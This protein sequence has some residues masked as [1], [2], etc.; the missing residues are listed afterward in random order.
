MQIL[1]ARFFW[2]AS[3][4]ALSLGA[5]ALAAAQ[6]LSFGQARSAVQ[7][8][9]PQLAA[10]LAAVASAQL[11]REGMEGLGGP[12]VAVTAMAY[13]YAANVDVGLDPARHALGNALGQFPAAA[14]GAIGQLPQLPSNYT[15]QR[16]D[17][18]ASASVSALWPVYMGGLSDA[19][20]EGLDGKT[21]EA[22]ADAALSQD[23]VH[24]LLV[25][26]YFTAQLAERAAILRRRALQGVRAHDDAAQRMLQAG[27]IAQVERLQASA[28]LADAQQQSQQADSAARLARSALAHTVQAPASVQPTTPLFVNQQPLAPLHDFQAAALQ[29][30]P[31]LGKVAAKRTQAEA[32]HGA[33]EALRKPQVL[34][35]GMR[36]VNTSGKPNWV[37]GMAVRWTLWDSMDRD[38]L[39]AAGQ[40]AIEQA[41]LSAAQVRSDIALLVE[42][43]WLAVEQAR[44]SYQAGQ[45]QEDLA[46]ELLRLRTAGFKEGT[47]TALEVIDAQLQVAKVQTARAS[48]ANDYVQ[49]L[50]ALLESSGQTAEFEQYMARADIVMS[51]DAP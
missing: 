36:E 27:V 20:R 35:F 22:Q 41:D 28:A 32:L 14:A 26:R 8:Q 43:N 40:R 7:S 6:P 33:S 16:Q 42:K 25:Q 3:W 38:K 48:A 9:S 34:A 37:A 49:A 47:S 11:R 51:P 13:R 50:A 39:A 29:A 31:G 5:P 21:Q 10:S 2:A 12:T 18:K 45:A 19:V 1:S 24:S 4:A 17:S 30:H 23:Q 44:S 15:L 46:R